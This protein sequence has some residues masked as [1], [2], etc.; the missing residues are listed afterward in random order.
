MPSR[1]RAFTLV[2]LLVVVGIILILITLLLPVVSR[3]RGTANNQICENNLRQIGMGMMMYVNGNKGR[4]PDPLTL[5]GSIYRRMVGEV[6]G[7]GLPEIYG[8]PALLDQSGLLPADRVTGGVW[9]CP[10]SRELFQSFKNTYIAGTRP[11]QR[12][13]LPTRENWDN[14]LV[15][16]NISVLPYRTGV[17]ALTENP[18]MWLAWG[19]GGTHL[20][21]LPVD[22]WYGP[23]T[24][25]LG[26]A[27]P[28]E[29]A[30]GVPAMRYPAN[31]FTHA[32]HADYSVH[33][34]Q[35]FKY[36]RTSTVEGGMSPLLVE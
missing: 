12:F 3:V 4:F 29:A 25:R 31:G 16:E 30:N 20:D 11:R 19:W 9:V 17:P 6:D 2:E 15:S 7:G 1:R 23:H 24:Y 10:V 34:Y 33:I 21:Q 14:P 32:L 35:H 13:G 36:V 22:Q 5:G 28:T 26:W 27:N 18:P 8:W